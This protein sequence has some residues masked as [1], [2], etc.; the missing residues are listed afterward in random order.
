MGSRP[1]LETKIRNG[2]GF[3]WKGR[4]QWFIENPTFWAESVLFRK[5]IKACPDICCFL[6]SADWEVYVDTVGPGLY[7][8]SPGLDDFNISYWYGPSQPAHIYI[9]F[10]EQ[11]HP[12]TWVTSLLWAV[13]N[14]IGGK[15]DS[16]CFW[17]G[18]SWGRKGD[19]ATFTVKLGPH[20][21][22]CRRRSPASH[23]FPHTGRSCLSHSR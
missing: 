15:T 20:A 18:L 10:I 19:P 9:H 23:S 16:T 17:V 12:E 4:L 5:A 11:W 21:F 8:W 7:S 6:P 2:K 13:I 3:L 22:P 14:H 1:C